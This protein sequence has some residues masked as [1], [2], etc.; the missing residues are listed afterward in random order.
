[1]KK[2]LRS[3]S[4]SLVQMNGAESTALCSRLSIEMEVEHQSCVMCD[5]FGRSYTVLGTVRSGVR[6]T[7]N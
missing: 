3:L 4:S 1:M 2:F 6:V 7:E 5:H